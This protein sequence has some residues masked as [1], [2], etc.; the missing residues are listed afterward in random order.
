MLKRGVFHLLEPTGRAVSLFF[1]GVEA[2]QLIVF[3]RSRVETSL[4]IVLSSFSS[5]H[6]KSIRFSPFKLFKFGYNIIDVHSRGILKLGLG[7]APLRLET[8]VAD[9]GRAIVPFCLHHLNRT[10]R[11]RSFLS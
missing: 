10:I 11:N 9:L 1:K 4:S 3:N 5:C 2:S 7:C 6:R 8:F